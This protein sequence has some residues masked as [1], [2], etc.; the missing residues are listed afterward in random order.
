[1]INDSKY[2]ESFYREHP[3]NKD[4]SS[5][6]SYVQER[7]LTPGKTLLELGCGNGRDSIYF[8]SKGMEVSAIDLAEKEIEFLQQ[9]KIDNAVFYA[10]SFTDLAEYKNFDFVYSRFTF[11]S[12]D[13]ES[14]DLVLSQLKGVLSK[15]GL[16]LL[17]A[18]SAKD[19]QLEKVFGTTHFRR[20]LNF[21]Q[22]I[23]KIEAQGFEILESIEA[24][25]LATYKQED[26]YVLRIVARVK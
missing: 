10:G 6:A 13:E 24:Q 23:A 17:E 21:E 19:E 26:P 15:D 9:L 5:F 3:V 2:W 12:I 16:F 22:T 7:Y 18:R 14:E 4:P 20:Y 1:M 8:A 25:G 11:H